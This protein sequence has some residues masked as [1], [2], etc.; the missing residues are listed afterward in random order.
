MFAGK[1]KA[2]FLFLNRNFIKGV[3]KGRNK[4]YAI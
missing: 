4:F 3:I 2:V 1:G